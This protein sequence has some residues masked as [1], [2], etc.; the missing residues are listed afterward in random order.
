MLHITSINIPY[1]T[2]ALTTVNLKDK[3]LV[4][5]SSFV[6]TLGGC[7]TGLH[8]AWKASWKAA[9]SWVDPQKLRSSVRVRSHSV[10]QKDIIFNN[11]TTEVKS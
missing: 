1:N 8:P 5:S 4:H 11:S 10:V 7:G 3:K 6:R 2:A 9:V